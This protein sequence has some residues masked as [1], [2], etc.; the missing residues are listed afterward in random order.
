MVG[1][2]LVTKP[3][4]LFPEP[5]GDPNVTFT[6][7]IDDYLDRDFVLYDLKGESWFYIQSR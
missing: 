4:F 5:S 7:I 6:S 1:I 2:I 3:P